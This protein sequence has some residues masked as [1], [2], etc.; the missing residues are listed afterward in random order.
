MQA[1]IFG[2]CVYPQPA[3]LANIQLNKATKLLRVKLESAVLNP[4]TDKVVILAGIV[5]APIVQNSK[6]ALVF[7]GST[8]GGKFNVSYFIRQTFYTNFI[9]S[10]CAAPAR[11][12]TPYSFVN[13]ADDEGLDV[14]SNASIAIFGCAPNNAAVLVN[15]QLTMDY[16]YPGG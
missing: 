8:Q 11:I 2:G 6:P 13:P 10:A 16:A 4:D 12:G 15:V 1:L 14:G 7:D 9:A 5:T 3:L